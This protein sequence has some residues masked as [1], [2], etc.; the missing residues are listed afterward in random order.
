M[1]DTLVG[2][3]RTLLWITL[4]ESSSG[5]LFWDTLDTANHPAHQ[6]H[7]AFTPACFALTSGTAPQSAHTLEAN[8]SHDTTNHPA[9]QRRAAFMPACF[10]QWH[11]A[12]QTHFPPRPRKS[13]WRCDIANVISPRGTRRPP[14]VMRAVC[15]T[16]V[17]YKTSVSYE[18][19][20]KS[21]A[22]SLQNKRFV[23]DFL[24][25]S[26]VKSPK[27]AFRTRPPP[28]V[29]R[30]VSKT[31]VSFR[32]RPPQKLTRQVS[33]MSVSYETSSRTHMSKSAK[34]AFRT[35]PR[36]KVTRKHPSEHTH[37][38]RSPTEQFRD[39]SPSKQHP[40]ARQS[41]CHSDIHLY[42]NSQPHGA[43]RLP[44]NFPR[45]HV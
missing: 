3:C 37:T 27:R 42:R 36:P 2:H 14:K 6:R 9:H 4:V 39:S 31:I 11:G 40:L 15:Q 18:T 44:R 32:T 34:R 26:R 19:S 35:R 43:L 13:A 12:T 7:A 41:Q 21:H 10:A 5:P 22:S 24:Q 38:S 1:W 30:Q 25:K 28:K 23:R 20:S 17:S 16:S 29:T 33:K 45:P 8:I